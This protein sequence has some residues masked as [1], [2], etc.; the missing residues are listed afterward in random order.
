M[1]SYSAEIRS[2]DAV[3]EFVA[4]TGSLLSCNLIVKVGLGLSPVLA[5]LGSA[6]LQDWSWSLVLSA[7]GLIFFWCFA[8]RALALRVSDFR[9]ALIFVV[10][11]ALGAALM[12]AIQDFSWDGQWYHLHR[13]AFLAPPE[14]IENLPAASHSLPAITYP[15]IVDNLRALAVSIF[16]PDRLFSG[17]A[18]NAAMVLVGAIYWIR[19]GYF[20]HPLLRPIAAASPVAAA[21]IFTY[22]IDGFLAVYGAMALLL[23]LLVGLELFGCFELIEL[24]HSPE[25][26]EAIVASLMLRYLVIF[27]AGGLM[28]AESKFS[29]FLNLLILAVP[30]LVVLS[31]LAFRGHGAALWRAFFAGSMARIAMGGVRLPLLVLAAFC[32]LIIANPYALILKEIVVGSTDTPFSWPI[33]KGLSTV[34]FRDQMTGEIAQTPAL[35]RFFVAQFLTFLPVDKYSPQFQDGSWVSNLARSWSIVDA[36]GAGFGVGA[37]VIFWLASGLSVHTLISHRFGAGLSGPMK[38]D[39]ARFDGLMK[40]RILLKRILGFSF[41]AQILISSIY[42]LGWWA[43]INPIPYATGCLLIMIFFSAPGGSDFDIVRYMCGLSLLLMVANLAFPAAQTLRY[44]LFISG[45][46]FRRDSMPLVSAAMALKPQRLTLVADV[47]PLSVIPVDAHA[48]SAAIKLQALDRSGRLSIRFVNSERCPAAREVPP[49]SSPW[50][51]YRYC[52]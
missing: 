22:Y 24:G 14:G 33:L 47:D 2:L 13:V 19:Y 46:N 26:F 50:W 12:P 43:R 39:V 40:K 49:A 38:L 3:R 15:M 32:L 52:P 42:G 28:F 1:S 51:F 5:P 9:L 35:M 48:L 23:I 27:L 11:S 17:I 8:G 30:C 21:Q 4:L 31:L 36:R 41:L 45:Q 44:N 34:T 18:L 7:L 10:L 6:F 16:A 29:F 37:L 25:G 20:L